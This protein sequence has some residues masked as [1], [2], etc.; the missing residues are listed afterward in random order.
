MKTKTWVVLVA[1]VALVALGTPA[2]AD[3]FELSLNLRAAGLAR[4]FSS[5]QS[6]ANSPDSIFV[7]ETPVA[8][9]TAGE[10]PP[11]SLTDINAGTLIASSSENN[12]WHMI[13]D[14]HW[15]SD[16]QWSKPVKLFSGANGGGD[17]PAPSVVPEPG[18]LIL[19]GSG[20]L[21]LAGV[22]RRRLGA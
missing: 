18:T 12:Q 9:Y 15:N 16:S 8:P 1:V 7:S 21:G 13:S 14:S 3:E 17:P 2:K 20:L 10:L 11:V 5:T 19:F 6:T 4:S 22:V